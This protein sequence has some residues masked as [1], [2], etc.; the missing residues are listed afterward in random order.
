MSGQ[1]INQSSR[2]PKLFFQ[3][4]FTFIVTRR[5]DD[6]SCVINLSWV[7]NFRFFNLA[8]SFSPNGWIHS[9]GR[10]WRLFSQQFYLSLLIK[11]ITGNCIK[12]N[13]SLRLS[14]TRNV[15]NLFLFLIFRSCPR[16]ARKIIWVS[17]TPYKKTVLKDSYGRWRQNINTSVELVVGYVLRTIFQSIVKI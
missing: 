2:E 11:K 4:I 17:T 7:Y 3:I 9:F 1:L 10:F 8:R 12:Q 6:D 13:R 14:Q 5:F 15:R 16:K